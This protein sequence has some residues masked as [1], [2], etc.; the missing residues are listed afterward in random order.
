MKVSTDA[1]I[2][3]A[4]TPLA[5][6]AKKVLDIGCGTGLLSLMIAQRQ[7]DLMID[8]LEIDTSAVQQAAENVAASP[9]NN[10]IQVLHKD[11]R[12]HFDPEPYDMIICNPPFF[13]GDLQAM[14]ESRNRARHDVSL[15]QADLFNIISANLTAQG[16]ACMMLPVAAHAL[17]EALLTRQGWYIHQALAVRPSERKS[18]NRIISVAASFPCPVRHDEE[19]MIYDSAGVYTEPFRELLKP[20]YL[21]L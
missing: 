1:C 18:V 8:A 7:P 20:Y 19:L 3:G 2:Q 12:T 9:W 15:S 4:W 11:A 13:S 17:W 5:P 14:N 6:A 10:R 16:T 21:Y